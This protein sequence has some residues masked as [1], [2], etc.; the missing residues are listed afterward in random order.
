[1]SKVSIAVIGL[2]GF[3]G[4]HVVAAIESGKY[5][6]KIEFPVK[7]ITRKSDDKSTEKIQYI[8]TAEIS[9][10]DTNL[11]S[12]LKGIDVL[13]ELTSPNPELFAN[14]EKII[15]LVK[16]KL[17]I[18]SQFGTD[19]PPVDAYAPGFLSLKTQHS[20]NVRKLGGIKVVDIITSLFA[21]PGAFLY[22]WV[23]AVGITDEGVNL[24]G[25]INQKFH[26]SKLEDI[27]NVILSVATFKSIE[28]LPDTLYVASDTITVKDVIDKY[29]K[30]KGKELKIISEKTAEDG[31]KEFADKLKAGFNPNDF[32][33]YLQA[34]I[35]QGLDK[36]LYFSKLDN[37]LVN[38]N[39][40]IWKWGKY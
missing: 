8:T 12:Q 29:S 1:M 28:D 14:I 19:I 7:A 21:A 30:A 9:A 20:E 40:S 39:E 3:L 16:P 15:E 31:K 18:P 34:I 23:N 11:I 22:E 6:S 5:D 4:K 33:F 25:D 13:I 10:K 36:G 24:I 26:V 17:F 38:P 37:E 2:H 32:T 35:S 27:G